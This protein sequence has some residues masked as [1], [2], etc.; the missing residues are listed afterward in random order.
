[1]SIELVVGPEAIT[2]YRRLPYK[3]W[4][5]IAE[6][7]DNSSQ[8][9]FNN[10]EVL[11][12][13]YEEDSKRQKRE[14]QFEVRVDYEKDNDLLRV[15]DNAM[16][17]DLEELQ[18]ALTVARPPEN[19]NGRSKYGMGLK[20][21]ACWLGNNWTIKTKKLG[22]TKEHI[23]KIDVT[24]L[25]TGDL[26]LD[27][28]SNAKPAEDHYTVVTIS[29]LN[30]QFQGR[31]LT[32]IRQYLS[33]I[34]R[35]DLKTDTMKLEWRGEELDWE[36]EDIS[37][38]V[39]A[40]TGKPF[41]KDLDFEVDGKSVTGWA[42]VLKKGGRGKAGFAVLYYGRVI[43][44]QPENA[45]RPQL[46]FKDASNDLINQRLTGELHL[47]EF[48][49]SHTKD[50][51]AWENNQE[52]EIESK[53]KELLIDYMAEAK[54]TNRESVG[55]T[56]VEKQTVI[57]D[58]KKEMESA[59]FIDELQF[60]TLPP[61]DEIEDTVEK[62]AEDTDDGEAELPARIALSP[63]ETLEIKGYIRSLSPND[64]YVAI[65]ATEPNEVIITIN[66]SHP[67][68]SEIRGSAGLHNFI[69]HCIYDGVA[70]WKARRIK[71]QVKPTT[72]KAI[73][74]RLLRVRLE[75]VEAGDFDDAPPGA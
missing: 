39:T 26:S 14:V 66:Q 53:L 41:K 38:F 43:R 11:T 22:E 6:L 50:D 29:N 12:E 28:K 1:M 65:K 54:V 72:I 3:P 33:S 61:E 36:D 21:S 5:A 45:W 42:G 74:D 64:P 23:V 31:T 27:L 8:N 37:N 68:W 56:D 59:E 24:K 67:H 71:T 51:I 20:T 75:M 2:N 62:I 4:Y 17:M 16:G 15:W 30:R 44:G 18:N 49:V 10:Q 47:D 52:E 48:E 9:F 32:K 63:S 57:E 40:E 35:H 7:V 60:E 19:P 69:K 34:Y 46:I 25:A 58:L 73:K 13:A 70:E 55:P